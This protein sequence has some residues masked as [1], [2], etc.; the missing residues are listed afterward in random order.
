MKTEE[1]F[2]GFD[3]LKRAVSMAQVLDRYGLT[4]QMRRSGDS[5]SGV[6]PLHQGHNPTQFRVSLSKNCWICFGDCNTGGSIVDFVSRKEGIGIRDA[7]LLIQDWFNVRGD[8]D[9]NGPRPNCNYAVSR[10]RDER[11]SN[12]P[13]GLSLGPLDT[14]HPYLT[15]RGLAKETIATF[16]LGYCS[17]GYLSGWMAIPIHN[18]GGKLLAYAGR[19]QGEP[20]DGAPKYRLPR[21]FRKSL[22][23]FNQHRAR[24]ESSSEPLVVVEGFFGCMRVW[25]AG[26][27]RVVSLMGSMLSQAQEELVERL[28]GDTGCVVLML[29]GDM[30]GRKGQ[31]EVRERLSRRKAVSVVHLPNTQQPD[32]LN[33]DALMALIRQHT[34]KE[35]AA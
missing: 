14:Q 9:P 15:E 27:R 33:D 5:L 18:A 32:S 8:P 10:L 7:A 28:A 35:M 31:A 6:C 34:L 4:E 19:W 30:A 26:H 13:L 29:D 22:E 12:P 24:A 17:R 11:W 21:G 20:P 25:Q 23:L 3:T 16:G 2:V 1:R